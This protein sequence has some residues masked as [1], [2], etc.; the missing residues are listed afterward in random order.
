MRLLRRKYCNL[1]CKSI[2]NRADVAADYT[3]RDT[4]MVISEHMIEVFHNEATF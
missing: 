4:K 1:T 2:T 3:E